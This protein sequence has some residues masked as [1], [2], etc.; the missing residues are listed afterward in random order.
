MTAELSADCERLGSRLD[1]F[2]SIAVFFSC[3]VTLS[4]DIITVTIVKRECN[5]NYKRIWLCAEVK[6]TRGLWGN[7]TR[8]SRGSRIFLTLDRSG[9]FILGASLQFASDLLLLLQASPSCQSSI[10]MDPQLDRL[11]E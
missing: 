5:I 6:E 1:A 11:F 10:M 9:Q 4:E 8:V 7:K 2:S 3:G